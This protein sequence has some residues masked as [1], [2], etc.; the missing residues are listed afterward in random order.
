MNCYSECDTLRLA[1]EVWLLLGVDYEANWWL[2]GC[3]EQLYNAEIV[4]IDVLLRNMQ[5]IAGI[6]Q[7]HAANVVSFQ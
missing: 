1:Y 2:S 5:L 6:Q 4:F 3:F 7:T